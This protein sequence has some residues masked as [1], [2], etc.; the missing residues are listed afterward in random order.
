MTNEQE[1]SLLDI[2]VKLEHISTQLESI[3]KMNLSLE[4]DTN[5]L[6]NRTNQHGQRLSVLESKIE[7]LADAA[8]DNW[9]RTTGMISMF[10]SVCAVLLAMFGP[11]LLT[12]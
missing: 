8:N 6:F 1:P 10:I 4:T 11:P 7:S 5:T 3:E 9:N 2:L 12:P